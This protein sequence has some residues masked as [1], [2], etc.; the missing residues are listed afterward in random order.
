MSLDSIY[1]LTQQR[2]YNNGTTSCHDCHRT[3]ATFAASPALATHRSGTA[4]TLATT[5]PAHYKFI[6]KFKLL[7][8]ESYQSSKYSQW[9]NKEKWKKINPFR[10]FYLLHQIYT[11]LQII[12]H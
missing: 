9:V 1:V 8:G 2:N 4:A 12:L 10:M 5:S 3:A 6:M 11:V 7:N